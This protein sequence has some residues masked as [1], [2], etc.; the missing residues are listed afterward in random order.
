[1]AVYVHAAPI[2]LG[3]GSV[4]EP[5]NFGRIVRQLGEAH[6]LHRREM[7]YEAV[8]QQEFPARLSRLDCLFCFPTADEAALAQQHLNGYATA[9]FY[10]VESP[11]DAPHLADMNN[12][13]LLHS[14]PSFD[15]NVIR[16][17][18]RGWQRSPDPQ[19]AVLREVLLGSPVKVLRR[20]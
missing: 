10:E 14:L 1:M 15:L 19:A 6:L 17:Y 7:A 2:L 20:L 4:I 12:G 9:A 11:E 18:W 3:L 13:I 8:R 5:G 16:Y